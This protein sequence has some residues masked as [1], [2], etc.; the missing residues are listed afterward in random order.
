M[1]KYFILLSFLVLPVYSHHVVDVLGGTGPVW[2]FAKQTEYASGD[3]TAKAKLDD[4]LYMRETLFLAARY[5]NYS[6]LGSGFFLWGAEVGAMMNRPTVSGNWVYTRADKDEKITSE[7]TQAVTQNSAPGLNTGRVSFHL[8]YN[9]PF[10]QYLAAE[11]GVVVGVGF[12]QGKYSY[13]SPYSTSLS[14]GVSNGSSGPAVNAALRFAL[15]LFPK[16]PVAVGLEYRLQ[17]EAFGS[18][19][20]LFPFVQSSTA[21]GTTTGHLFLISVGY[22]FGLGAENPGVPSGNFK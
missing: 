14:T 1:L 8:G 3:G 13:Q 19:F 4:T 20:A 22:R 16:S 12:G 18:F 5:S 11:F 10:N 2:G 6:G 21:L 17:A 9:A 15:Q 7:T